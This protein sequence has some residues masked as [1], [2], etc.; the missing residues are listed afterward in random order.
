[1][2]GLIVPSD[3]SRSPPGLSVYSIAV[4]GRVIVSLRT[5]QQRKRFHRG[6]LEAEAWGTAV[7]TNRIVGA[8]PAEEIK[9]LLAKLERM[10]FRSNE[11]VFE[12]S[13]PARYVYFPEGA[14]VS[15]RATME[16]GRSTE[17]SLTGT[18]GFMGVGGFLGAETY[19]YTALVEIPG[20]C[21]RMETGAF[22][23][24]Y[25]KGGALQ[26]R[27]LSYL[28]HLLAQVSQTAA[29]NRLHRVSQRL[30]RRLLMMHDRVRNNEFPMTHESLSYAL[31]TPRSEVSFAAAALRRLKMIDYVR[32]KVA[33]VNREE[34]ESVSCE[35]YAIIANFN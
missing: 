25:R 30:A 22:K 18:E 16:D 20:S 31:G 15:L 1:M 24:E 34:L 13:D 19:G 26:A 33:I 8:V 3:V 4:L 7:S 21:L 23:A 27:S 12:P 14:V 10:A 11:V 9:G 29:C 28:R 6:F 35:C 17:V 2:T 32:G 5:P